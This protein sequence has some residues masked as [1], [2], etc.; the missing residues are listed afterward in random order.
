M[1]VS[2]TRNVSV[3]LMHAID[4]DYFHLRSMNFVQNPP[5]YGID[6]NCNGL[7]LEKCTVTNFLEWA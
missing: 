6:P 5:A 3:G 2:S 4:K 1:V 7:L